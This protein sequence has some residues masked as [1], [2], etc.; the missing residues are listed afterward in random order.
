MCHF[1]SCLFMFRFFFNFFFVFSMLFSY[2][3]YRVL[4]FVRI[5]RPGCT[6]GPCPNGSQLTGC[7]DQMW[8][9]QRQACCWPFLHKPRTFFSRVD[10]LSCSFF[11][12]FSRPPSR[13]PIVLFHA[14]VAFY[15]VFSFVLSCRHTVAFLICRRL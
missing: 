5:Q 2:F 7:L 4:I 3:S 6:A 11:C 10:D 1:I 8:T 15:F 12:F 14:K 13:D 9:D